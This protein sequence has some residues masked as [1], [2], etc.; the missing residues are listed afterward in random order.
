VSFGTFTLTNFTFGTP[1]GTLSV[2]V[3]VVLV[4]QTTFWHTRIVLVILGTIGT[5]RFRFWPYHCIGHVILHQV[6]KFIQI[7]PSSVELWCYIN[8]KMP[9]AEA[10]IYFRFRIWR[11]RSLQ[12]IRAYQQTKFHQSTAEI[13]LFPVWKNKRPP[14]WNS[15]SGFDFDHMT[16]VGMSFCTSLPD[17]I[18]KMT[19]CRFLRWWI[20]AILNFM[21]PIMGTSKSPCNKV[22]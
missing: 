4:H 13:Q 12:K 2:L 7:G 9:D 21:D 11:R 16:A 3:V 15:T 10:Q 14:Y 20:S 22:K 5:V 18:P 6:V 17:F 19:S 1:V 8:F